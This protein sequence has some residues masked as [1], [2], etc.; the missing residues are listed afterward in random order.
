VSGPLLNARNNGDLRLTGLVVLSDWRIRY[1]SCPI[2][3]P[4]SH[5]KKGLH[6]KVE[7]VPCRSEGKYAPIQLLPMPPAVDNAAAISA[8]DKLAINDNPPTIVQFENVAVR[9][10]VHM[11][12]PN[13]TGISETKFIDCNIGQ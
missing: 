12:R 2:H 7:R 10:P 13:R 5:A 1:R 11:K 8:I 6:C 4:V 3:Q 9:P